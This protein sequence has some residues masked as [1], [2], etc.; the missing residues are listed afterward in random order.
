MAHTASGEVKAYEVG[1]DSNVHFDRVASPW[2]I[3][4]FID[5]DAEFSFVPRNDTDSRPPDAIPVA[6]PGTTLGPHDENGT[7]FA[8]I[9]RE[10][11]LEDP[12]LHLMAR[13]IEAGVNFVVHDYHPAPDDYYGQIGVGY[14]TLSDG[15][16]LVEKSD[17]VRL[18][19]SYIFYDALYELFKANKQR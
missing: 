16:I 5:P 14:I 4:R 15:M 9:L 13:V 2:V 3:K 11:E 10:Y 8:K 6:I 17:A 12:A 7:T 19:K 1:N 18:D